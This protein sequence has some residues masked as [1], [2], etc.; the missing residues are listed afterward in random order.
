MLR[1]FAWHIKNPRIRTTAGIVAGS[2]LLAFIL[3]LLLPNAF[4]SW[5]NQVIDQFIRLRYRLI[6]KREVSPYLIHVVVNDTSHRVLELPS[7]DRNVFGQ[8]IDILQ[9][10]N[11]KLIACDVFFKD[12][13]YP[14]N[15]QLL[16]EATKKSRKVI[17]PILVYP[18]GY[19]NFQSLEVLADEYKD[20]V[21]EPR[22]KCHFCGRTAHLEE[23]LCK[24]MKL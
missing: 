1:R 8:V 13:S 14:D 16:L 2:F 19:F 3:S 4:T 22:Y 10:T 20:L 9:D 24:P 7:W 17:F 23:S 18:E 12:T 21:E 15:D 5:N 6:G 11:V